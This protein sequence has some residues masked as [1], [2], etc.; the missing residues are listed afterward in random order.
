METPNL[1]YLK[2]ISGGDVEFEQK[3]LSILKEELPTEVEYYENTIKDSNFEE[4]AQIVHKL[5]HKISILGMYKAYSFAQDYEKELKT[6]SAKQHDQF[7]N[8]LVTM[9]DFLAI[10]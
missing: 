6:G 5:K 3:M 2:E 9:R 8:V 7:K 4:S 10:N 1:N